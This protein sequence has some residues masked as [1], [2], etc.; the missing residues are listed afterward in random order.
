MTLS[1]PLFLFLS[2]SFCLFLSLLI[3]SFFCIQFFITPSK[4]VLSFIISSLLSSYILLLFLLLNLH[5]V[6]L[7]R[8]SPPLSCLI[9]TPL[10]GCIESPHRVDFINQVVS[11]LRV[12]EGAIYNF[13]NTTSINHYCLREIG[14]N[15]HTI[16]SKTPIQIG[17][18][19]QRR[20]L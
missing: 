20:P 17:E 19:D 4:F 12:N 18:D 9:L 1:Q 14:M 3:F 6:L 5:S 13:A 8:L 16:C 2:L 7:L 15:G 10:L 11:L